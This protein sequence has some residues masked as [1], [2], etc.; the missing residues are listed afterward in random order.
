MVVVVVVVVTLLY[1]ASSR[2][3]VWGGNPRQV[4]F[5]QI[6]C[7]LRVGPRR[8]VGVRTL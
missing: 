8:T 7:N 3:V 2:V 5:R 6:Q 4:T 1:V